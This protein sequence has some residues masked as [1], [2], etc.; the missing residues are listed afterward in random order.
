MTKSEQIKNKSKVP[1]KNFP[2][3]IEIS[4]QNLS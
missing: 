4:T 1:L 3:P 2:T